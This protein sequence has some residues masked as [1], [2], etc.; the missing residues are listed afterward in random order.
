MPEVC[1]SR[2]RIVTRAG[3]PSAVLSRLNSG[4]YFSTGS[5]TERRPSSW[6]INSS[7]A[8]TGLLIEA[9]QNVESVRIVSA[10]LSAAWPVASRWTT[11]S[12]VATMVTAPASPRAT[13]DWR[14]RS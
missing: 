4:K 5:G 1:V 9:I 12:G 8:R 11:R 10:G 6:S 3:R 7:V 14:R 2:W 13:T